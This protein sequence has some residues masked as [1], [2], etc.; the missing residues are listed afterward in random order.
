MNTYAGRAEAA[1]AKENGTRCFGLV[2]S[3]SSIIVPSLLREARERGSIVC[4]RK[5]DQHNPQRGST[6]YTGTHTLQTELSRSR[7]SASASSLCLGCYFMIAPWFMP[8]SFWRRRRRAASCCCCYFVSFFATA[9]CI[10]WDTNVPMCMWVWVSVSVAP[11]RALCFQLPP[12]SLSVPLLGEHCKG[13][14]RQLKITCAFKPPPLCPAPHPP[15]TYAFVCVSL[16]LRLNREAAANPTLRLWLRGGERWRQINTIKVDTARLRL[17]LR[18]I[19]RPKR[20]LRVSITTTTPC[21]NGRLLG[22]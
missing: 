19:P 12:F 3:P 5:R 13:S 10:K 11:R 14:S 8:L 9:K 17:R 20:S 1:L 18:F 15:L 2:L 22:S 21:S 6:H 16:P 4:A 7:S